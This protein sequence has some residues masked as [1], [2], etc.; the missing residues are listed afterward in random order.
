M[1]KWTLLPSCNWCCIQRDTSA[2]VSV[3][4]YSFSHPYKKLSRVK[5]SPPPPPHRKLMQLGFDQ[6]LLLCWWNIIILHARTGTGVLNHIPAGGRRGG[7]GW[8]PPFR[9]RDG[10]LTDSQWTDWVWCTLDVRWRRRSI[11]LLA[12]I[13]LVGWLVLLLCTVIC[14]LEWRVVRSRIVFEQGSYTKSTIRRLLELTVWQV[15]P[16]LCFTVPPLLRLFRNSANLCRRHDTVT[17]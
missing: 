6:I 12:G 11:S 7:T 2:E 13:W 8:E 1:N 16:Y 3:G 10:F 9:R 17:T 5:Y 15:A 4:E 14:S